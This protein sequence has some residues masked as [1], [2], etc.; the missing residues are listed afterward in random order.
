MMRLFSGSLVKLKLV[1]AKRAA[2]N[3]PPLAMRIGQMVQANIC[4]TGFAVPN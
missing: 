2:V 4:Q 3:L 1:L